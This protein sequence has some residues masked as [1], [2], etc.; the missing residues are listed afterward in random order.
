MT[1]SS[2]TAL[3]VGDMQTDILTRFPFARTPLDP[4]RVTV[5][6]ARAHGVLVVF[7]HTELRSS[8]VDVSDNNVLISRFFRE[9][10]LF[11]A[12]AGQSGVARE[13]APLPEDAVVTK[14]RA[15]AFTGTDLDLILRAQ[16]IDSVVLAGVATSG[17]VTATAV[18]ALDRDYRVT[19]LRDA[20][21]DSDADVHD[22]LVNRFLP[23][24][25]T[26]VRTS[27]EWVSEVAK[28]KPGPAASMR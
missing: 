1:S 16:H 18:E 17:V 2:H 19:V 28:R 4:L 10:G 8:G 24:R 7:V 3:I 26:E 11:H 13:F 6:A 15:S 21:A 14:R 9:E 23:L 12:D 20:C 25:G 27:E 5:P 22:F